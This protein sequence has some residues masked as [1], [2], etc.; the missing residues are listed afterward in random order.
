MP[1]FSNARGGDIGAAADAVRRLQIAFRRPEAVARQ[2]V[3]EE[4]GEDDDAAGQAR[5]PLLQ[6]KSER[7]ARVEI[8]A[9]ELRQAAAAKG[10]HR[11]D[12]DFLAAF[13]HRDEERGG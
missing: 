13:D 10:K 5:A 12:H 4:P 1:T 11:M 7:I 2:V 3:A 6:E 8:D 9:C